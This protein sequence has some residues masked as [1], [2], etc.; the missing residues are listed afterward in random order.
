[1]KHVLAFA[2]AAL[3]GGCASLATLAPE[4]T[5][6][7]QEDGVLGAVEG[8]SGV[9]RRGCGVIAAPELQIAIDALGA[10]TGSGS[11][12]APVRAVRRQ[13]C[14]VATVLNEVAHAAP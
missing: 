10:V 7:F 11:I 3:L 14:G 5:A 12:V 2:G 4:T 8:A 13:V 9:V 1:M 6:G